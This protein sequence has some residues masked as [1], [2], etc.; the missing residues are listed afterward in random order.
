VTMP[1]R[2][3]ANVLTLDPADPRWRLWF[4]RPPTAREA[5]D[6][7]WGRPLPDDPEEMP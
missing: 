6:A 5:L 2:P 4:D 3:T 7:V 1:R